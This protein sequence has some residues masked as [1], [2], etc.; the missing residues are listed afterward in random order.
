[1]FT[2]FLSVLVGIDCHL[3]I[4]Y[5][6]VYYFSSWELNRSYHYKLLTLVLC[7]NV[8]NRGM[9]LTSDINLYLNC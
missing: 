4:V 7:K 9:T 2:C 8:S 3:Y 6:I 5:P 1:M